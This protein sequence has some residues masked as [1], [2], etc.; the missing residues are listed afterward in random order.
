MF[1]DEL[2]R[3]RLDERVRVVLH[4][5]DVHACHVESGAAVALACPAR[6]AEQVK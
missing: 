1:P 5:L 4:R 6:A 3:I 2:K